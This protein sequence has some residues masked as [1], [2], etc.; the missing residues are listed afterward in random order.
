MN[1]A[2]EK[3][4]RNISLKNVRRNWNDEAGRGGE[5]LRLKAKSSVLS[6]K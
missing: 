5:T 3:K 2:K 1:V 6:I 4:D